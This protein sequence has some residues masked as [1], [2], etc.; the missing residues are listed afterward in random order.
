M[1]IASEQTI[2]SEARARSSMQPP[3]LEVIEHIRDRAQ[4]QR[5][6]AIAGFSVGI[7]AIAAAMIIELAFD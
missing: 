4:G 5:T 2:D 6:L 1:L 3:E 7:V